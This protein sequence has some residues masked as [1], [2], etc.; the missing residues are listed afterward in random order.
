MEAFISGLKFDL[1]VIKGLKLS[2][3]TS[4]TPVMLGR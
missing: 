1:K 2:R 4:K 3:L